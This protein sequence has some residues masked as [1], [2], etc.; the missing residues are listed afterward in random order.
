LRRGAKATFL[1]LLDDVEAGEEI[2]ITRRGKTI[3]RL[4]PAR[5]PHALK[6]LFA[7]VTK[8]ADPNDDLLST[9][10]TWDAE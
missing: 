5:G 2:R 3:A 8:T 9:G 4:A 1:S 6:N 7:G 10:L